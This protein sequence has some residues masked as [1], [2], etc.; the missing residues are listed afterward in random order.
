MIANYRRMPPAQLDEL[1][2]QPEQL[3]S[4][5]YPEDGPDA[6]PHLDL[7]KDLADCVRPIVPR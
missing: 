3:L 1:L 5:L 7:D 2:A 4:F 6:I